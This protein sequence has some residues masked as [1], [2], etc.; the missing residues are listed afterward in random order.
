M[1]PVARQT[2]VLRTSEMKR[3]LGAV[4]MHVLPER[5]QV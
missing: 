3:S 4:A 1:R 2:G 5:A